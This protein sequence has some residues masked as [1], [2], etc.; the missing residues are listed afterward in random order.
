MSKDRGQGRTQPAKLSIV[1]L[2]IGGEEELTR[3]DN[4]KSSVWVA[5]C[6]ISPS[7]KKGTREN[8]TPLNSSLRPRAGRNKE[9][10]GKNV[11]IVRSDKI[12]G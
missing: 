8:L 5:P 11:L 7:R 1:T 9:R 12:V 6:P 4:K 2:Q 10:A 3:H